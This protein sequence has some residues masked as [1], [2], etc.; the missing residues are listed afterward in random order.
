MTSYKFPRWIN[1]FEPARNEEEEDK[2]KTNE[3]E[4][5]SEMESDYFPLNERNERA[6]DETAF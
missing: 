5:W 4:Q 6:N 1:S 3:K 2:K